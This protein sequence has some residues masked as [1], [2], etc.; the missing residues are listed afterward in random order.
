MLT[1]APA[2]REKSLSP[3]NTLDGEYYMVGAEDTEGASDTVR[4]PG[5]GSPR[6]SGEEADPFLRP[7]SGIATDAGS[8]R[9]F[10]QPATRTKMTDSSGS[11]NWQTTYSSSGTPSGY[12]TGSS[13]RGSSGQG[14]NSGS[15]SGS[16]R[17]YGVGVFGQLP[18]IQ[19]AASS[20]TEDYGA[21]LREPTLFGGQ[22]R[23]PWRGNIL[24]PEEQRHLDEQT[25]STP[26]TPYRQPAIPESDKEDDFSPLMP[27]PRL[28]D[29]EV[30]RTRSSSPLDKDE[31]VV[32]QTAQRVRMSD[33]GPRVPRSHSPILEVDETEHPSPPSSRRVSGQSWLGSL[34][35]GFGLSRL[36]KGSSSH[37]DVEAGQSLLGSSDMA[38]RAVR[39][40]PTHA[41]ASSSARPM[42]G[43]SVN[44]LGSGSTVFFDAP[45]KPGT[46]ALVPPPRA[47]TP[48]QESRSTPIA[49]PAGDKP[50][51]GQPTTAVR[52]VNSIT[53]EMLDQPAPAPLSTFTSA[54]SM[55]DTVHTD[56]TDAT[57]VPSFP[58]PGLALLPA[59]MAWTRDGTPEMPSPGYGGYH[60]LDVLEEE[61]PIPGAQWR[62]IAETLPQGRGPRTTFG[63]PTYIQGPGF[64]SEQASLY[65]MRSHIDPSITR[66]TGSA[67][68]S[69][70]NSSHPSRRK[71]NGSGSTTG[72]SLAHSASITSDGRRRRGPNG[73]TSPVLSA[74]GDHARDATGNSG[75]SGS[76]SSH[77]HGSSSS[78]THASS[79]HA[80]YDNNYLSPDHAQM[81]DEVA[82]GSALFRRGSMPWA[83]GLPA[84]WNPAY[85][86]SDAH[87]P[88]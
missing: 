28:V 85:T 73:P 36:L 6:H 62:H 45:S 44:T 65:S 46:P 1:P 88:A 52:R 16:R 34:A 63:M 68:A 8:M 25:A 77:A 51:Y 2:K 55:R 26:P 13:G 9:E 40:R 5:E 81:S 43:G 27:P 18:S 41:G 54:S 20:S 10:G 15:G 53:S 66:S 19:T 79:A 74:F 48:G 59:P 14:T 84:D 38:E 7:R 57:K 87:G 23:E 49:S 11:S 72:S 60:D 39:P 33:V 17:S 71:G 83:G 86:E 58:P 31:P 64:N 67:P 35:G 42:S 80:Q 30:T 56:S 21:E 12:Q 69:S 32:V 78:H 47:F 50:V 24:T 3:R 70:L 75:P 22:R 37:K 61:P 82:Q 29:P 76:G 4:T